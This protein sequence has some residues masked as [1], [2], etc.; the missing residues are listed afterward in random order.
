MKYILKI[1]PKPTPRPRVGKFGAYYPKA[2]QKH[3]DMM[4]Y[5]V[6]DLK[7]PPK[8]YNELVVVFYLPF[9]TKMKKEER[10]PNSYCMFRGDL[11]N[12]L[13]CLLDALQSCEVIEDDRQFCKITMEKRFA[14]DKDG[15]I[16]FLLKEI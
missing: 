8:K 7:I 1:T 3:K 10:I 14:T 9:L 16:K 2:Y 6:N 5:L 15:Y 12:Y 11:D 13:K 4:H